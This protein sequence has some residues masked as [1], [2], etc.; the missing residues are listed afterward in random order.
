MGG[1]RFDADVQLSD[2]VYIWESSCMGG[3]RF[4]ADVQLRIF[5]ITSLQVNKDNLLIENSEILFALCLTAVLKLG[6]NQIKNQST[7]Y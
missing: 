3:D 7:F 6:S 2:Q 4:D 1:D 5:Q